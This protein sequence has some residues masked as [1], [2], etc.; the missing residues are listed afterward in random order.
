MSIQSAAQKQLL[1][2]RGEKCVARYLEQHGFVVLAQNVHTRW[3]EI[4]ILVQQNGRLHV[5]EVKTR[6]STRFGEAT[7]ALTRVKFL[8]IK[9]SMSDLLQR[10]AGFSGPW[11]I[12]FAVVELADSTASEHA[13]VTVFWNVGFDDLA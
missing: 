5:V 3:G 11:Q 6:A 1:G 2:K 7:A 9:K 12:D 4:D 8:K 13:R 10:S